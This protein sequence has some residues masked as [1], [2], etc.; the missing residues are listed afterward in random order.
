MPPDVTK[1][2]QRKAD[3]RTCTKC[4]TPL[5]RFVPNAICPRCLL[6]AG[7]SEAET[8]PDA[9]SINNQLPHHQPTPASL[10]RFDDYELLD[11]IAQGGMG[12]VYRARQVSLNRI[13]ALKMIL[14]GQ[15]A[16]ETEVKRFRAEAEAAAQLDHPNIVPIYEVGEWNGHHFFSM[17]LIEGGTLT[18]R[19][20]DPKSRLSPRAAA[21]LLVKVCRAVHFAHQHGILHRDLKP[22]NILLDAEG[23]PHV[24]DFGLAK[25]MENA[26]QVTLSGV[27]LGSPSY[28]A[29]EQA[30]G[31]P[32]QVTIAADVY[33]LGAI[34]YEMLTGRPPFHADTPLATL[35]QV[36][37]H[38]P[39]R[40]STINLHADPDLETICLKC[41]EKEPQRRYESAQAL[42]QDLQR[43]LRHEPIQARAIGRIGRVAKWT[44]RH[45]GTATLLLLASLATLAFLVG[46]TITSVRLARANREV[47]ASNER[48][49]RSLYESRWQQAEDGTRSEAIAWFSHFLRQNPND[50]TAA[51]RLLSLLSSR[52]FPM[53]L[54]PPLVHEGV[55]AVDFGR[56]GEH[57]ATIASAKTARLWNIQSGQME[58][59]FAHP[60][61]LTHC[62]LGGDRDQRLLTISAEP[63]ARLW[64]L[65]SREIIKEI[66]LGVL[67]ERSGS[68]RI[69]PTRD[70]RLMAINVRSNV[71]AVLDTECGAWLA[72]PLSL[73]AEI[74]A[75]ALAED[76]RMLATA[77]RFEVQLWDTKS[78]Q[79]LCAPVALSEPLSGLW[80]SEDGRWL[81]CM[82]GRKAWAMNTATFAREREFPVPAAIAFVGNGET[83]ITTANGHPNVFNFRTGADCGSAFGQPQFDWRHPSLAALRFSQK[84][85]DHVTLLDYATGQPQ[86]EPFFH[87]SWITHRTLHPDGRTVATA[88]Q[89]GT[90][91][92]WSAEMGK[93]EPI[94]LQTG[95]NVWEAQ[96]S[97][98]GD[99]ILATCTPETGPELR[100]WDAR[101]GA[102]LVPPIKTDN[103]LFVAKW[104]PDGS[105]FATASQDS[106]ARLWN[107]QTGE[108]ISPPLHHGG[109]LDHCSFSPDGR[110]LATASTDRTI[111]LWDGYS[112]KAIGAPLP[113]SQAP[114]KV[115][116]S[117]DG[118]RLATAC[119]DGTI[120]VWSVPDLRRGELHEPARL[121]L[122]PLQHEGACWVAAF[123]PDDRLLVSA[124]SDGTVRLWDAATGRRTLPPFRHEGPVL[125]ATFSPDGRAIA[126]STEAGLVRVWDALTGQPLAQPMRHP[127]RVWFVQWSPGGDFLATTCTDGAARVWHARS[128][129]LAAEPFWHRKEVRRA[130]FSPDERRLLTASFDG[131]VKIWEL[132]LLR[133]PV[134]VPDWLPD[135][136]ESLG[137]KR[138]GT[139]EA[140]KSISGD[141]LQRVK[142]RLAQV[143]AQND[144]YA[145]WAKWMLHERLERPVK[146]FQP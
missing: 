113:H 130:E 79:P 9:P 111:R 36:V 49:S 117:A 121:L 30:A 82:S 71:I 101:T 63:T 35:Q 57:L 84:S 91:R 50:S 73:P 146:P 56:T 86:L 105:R 3:T 139:E 122:G 141:S 126:T 67:D 29:P 47:R 5:G 100:L 46:Q 119:L 22:G 28:M 135:L 1:Q 104:A 110:L 10:G 134:P 37:E 75:F 123:S 18:R 144:Y 14:T 34:L 65:N 72:Q 11:E 124:S 94:T 33:S 109:P 106:T 89:D 48:L 80:F 137:G 92:V 19:L 58:T 96:W 53:L 138:I 99:R 8:D 40:P 129:H 83:L 61:K 31:K 26:D 120:R 42:E 131:T 21:A 128:G 78:N 93:P 52:N 66:S 142:Q 15:F 13:V 27:M 98:G 90:V 55:N 88:S 107:G 85:G 23:E 112:G 12:I 41:L 60:A 108:P 24:S 7:L 145:R 116:F 103:W 74:R 76:G 43:W 39:R 114:L 95:G 77:S 143:P 132:V 25:S 87:D 62:L 68:R 97:P 118:R 17:R 32:S 69:L 16:S 102:A 51:A 125:W 70:R 81:A 2:S 133:P 20:S 6:Q 4:G 44:R 38:E 45:P 127:D 64:D 140:P 115:N 59:E 136:A 54:H